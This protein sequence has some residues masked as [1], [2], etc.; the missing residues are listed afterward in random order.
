MPSSVLFLTLKVFSAT[1]GVEKVCQIAGK[2]LYE[3]GLT[4]NASVSILSMHDAQETAADNKYFPN[5]CFKGY[6]AKKVTFTLDAVKYGAKADI[7]LLSHI[8]LLPIAWLIKKRNPTAKV[9]LLAHG[10]EIWDKLSAPRQKMLNIVN[11]FACVSSFTKTKIEKVHSIPAQQCVVL[12]NCI[13]P[14]LTVKANIERSEILLNRYKLKKEDF[15]LL[16]LTRISERD[17]YKGYATVIE[18]MA[19]L[20]KQNANI[21]YM[22]AGGYEQTEKKF[23]DD[24]LELHKIES[25]VIFTGYVLNEEI[26]EHFSLADIYVMPS[27]KEG[28]GIVFV[29]AMLYGKPVIAANADGSTDAL[30]Q[31]KLGVLVNPNE[32]K[33]IE[34]SVLEILANKEKYLPNQDLLQKYFSYDAYK[35]NIENLLSSHAN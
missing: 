12:N 1:G 19:H 24:L 8:N 32:P 14:F 16:T 22:L 3:Y 34:T 25:N 35:A 27:V 13:D 20:V 4:N 15:I 31:G 9:I 5:E 2:A 11:T 10:I 23:I 7:V 17:R 29:E 28:F 26:A 18:A 21:K 6:A 33:E 30:L